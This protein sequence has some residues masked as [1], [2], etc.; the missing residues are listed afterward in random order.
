M[1]VDFPAPFSPMTPWIVPASTRRLTPALASTL[2]NCFVSPRNS[3]AAGVSAV[4]S[5]VVSG[6]GRVSQRSGNRPLTVGRKFQRS[7]AGAGGCPAWYTRGNWE[8][9]GT[10]SLAFLVCSSCAPRVLLWSWPCSYPLSPSSTWRRCS[11]TALAAGLPVGSFSCLSPPRGG[12]RFVL[13]FLRHGRQNPSQ[14]HC[15]A[16]ASLNIPG[17]N[18]GLCLLT[19]LTVPATRLPVEAA[20]IPR[21]AG[22]GR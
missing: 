3:T 8:E 10:C 14:P 16:M 11:F 15:D 9:V 18:L 2:P 4:M 13:A 6:F 17:A 21:V 12:Q 19:L 22:K 20:N 7:E 5:V 1:A